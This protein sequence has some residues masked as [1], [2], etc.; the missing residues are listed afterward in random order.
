MVYTCIFILLLQIDMP[1]IKKVYKKLYGV[2]ITE[3]IKSKS[4]P[5]QKCLIELANKVPSSSKKVCCH[6]INY[7]HY[8][9]DCLMIPTILLAVTDILFWIGNVFQWNTLY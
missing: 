2:D 1:E 3:D 9:N 8:L 6:F 7:F 5:T 4:H